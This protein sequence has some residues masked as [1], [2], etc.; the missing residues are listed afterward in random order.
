VTILQP[1]DNG[2]VRDSYAVPTPVAVTVGSNARFVQISQSPARDL[3]G[4]INEAVESGAPVVPFEGDILARGRIP[5]AE[6][7]GGA[8]QGLEGGGAEEL[9]GAEGP[10]GLEG[11]E[12][13]EEDGQALGGG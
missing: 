9:E 4:Q 12:L 2:T 1:S 8:A 3:Q 5:L 6:G 11:L 10:Q 13:P 7:G